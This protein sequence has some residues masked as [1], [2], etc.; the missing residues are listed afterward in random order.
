[1]LASISLACM[2]ETAPLTNADIIKML[3]AKLP[4]SVIISKVQA[5][6]GN[7]DTSTDAII[8]L[9]KKGVGEKLLNAM[10]TPAKGAAEAQGPENAPSVS[11]GEKP[12]AL[13]YGT[14]SALVKK[15]VTTQREIIDLFGGADVMTTDKDGTEV[16]MYD[17]K[18]STVATSGA[19]N[20][21]GQQT[22]EAS[23]MAAFLGIP[24]IAGVGTA[25]EKSKTDTAGSVQSTGEVKSSSKNITFIIKFNENKT[26]KD[27][28]VRQASY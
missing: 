25:K 24:F 19:S 8:E 10:L 20:T 21:T 11:S 5:S 14:A 26:V 16:W 27:F 23:Q 6:K 9:N 3:D 28:A 7:F 13:S 4:E 2:A 15:G 22:S 1:M 12:S 17:K 18:T